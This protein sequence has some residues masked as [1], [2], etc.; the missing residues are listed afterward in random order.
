MFYYLNFTG[1]TSAALT[2]LFAANYPVKARA[3]ESVFGFL[4]TTDLLPKGGTEIEQWL[5]WRR[6]KECVDES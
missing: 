4:V 1:V 3:G 6:Q 2:I 5:T